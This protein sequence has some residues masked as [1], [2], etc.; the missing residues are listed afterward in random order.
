MEILQLLSKNEI[1]AQLVNFLILL[2]IMRVFFW[3]RI[4]AFLEERRSRIESE[5]KNIESARQEAE[6][7]KQE[8]GS[9]LRAI[10]EE[11]AARMSEAIDLGKDRAEEIK[12]RAHAEAQSI[13]DGARAAMRFEVVKAREEIK[14]EIIDLAIEATKTVIQERLTEE[15]DKKLIESFLQKIDE[16]K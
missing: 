5:L 3:K 1:V 12:R 2:A 15:D 16:K 6:A 14:E 7:L 8:Y 10:E 9:K 11:A 4:L 13:V